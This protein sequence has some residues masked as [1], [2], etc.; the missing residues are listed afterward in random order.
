MNALIVAITLILTPAPYALIPGANWSNEAV[1][2]YFTGPANFGLEHCVLN[3]T[4]VADGFVLE[5]GGKVALN[6]RFVGCLN[7]A[8]VFQ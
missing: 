8:A 1:R 3:V 5:N 4:Q 2:G 7:G 6:Q